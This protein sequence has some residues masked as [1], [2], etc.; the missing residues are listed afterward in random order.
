MTRPGIYFQAFGSPVP[1]QSFRYTKNG[2]YI[3][4]RV[5]N[6]QTVVSLA[7]RQAVAQI[8]AWTPFA[9][10]LVV[11]L[12]FTLPTHRRVDCDNLSKNVLDS[13][14][15]ILWNDDS[16]VIDLRIRKQFGDTPGVAVAVDECAADRAGDER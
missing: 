2:G 14:T 12:T 16:Q 15:G 9:G 6:W 8:P 11:T 10:E 5:K 7:A 3:E 13:L 1:K 4:P